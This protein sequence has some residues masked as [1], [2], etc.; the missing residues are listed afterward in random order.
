[1]GGDMAPPTTT[2]PLAIARPCTPQTFLR[3]QTCPS[4]LDPTN[5]RRGANVTDWNLASALLERF[6][7][8]EKM[9]PSD[10]EKLVSAVFHACGHPVVGS[11]FVESNNGIDL[12]IETQL[13][14]ILQ[15]ISVEVKYRRGAA[16]E[17]SIRQLISSRDIEQLHRTMIVSR[18]G[19]T[20]GALRM[21]A[22]NGVGNLDLL[23]PSDLHNWL[24][25]H[26]PQVKT[27]TSAEL[28]VRAAMRSLAKQ[29]AEAPEELAKLEWRDLERVLREV[30]EGIGFGTHLTRPGKDGGF[31]LELTTRSN[32]EATTYLVEVKHWIGQKLGSRHLNKFVQVTTSRRATG[33]LLL[34][35]SGFTTSFHEGFAEITAPVRLGDGAK[36]VSL[37][38]V[39]FR[40]Q[41]ALW[42]ED[43]SLEDTLFDGTL[44]PQRREPL[45]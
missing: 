7:R 27:D 10:A 25:K 13:D 19:F 22:E 43:R 21:A 30:F 5:F 3:T 34:S 36:V 2:A 40:L 1:M 38:K 17:D 12:F 32:G 23:S 31:D 26:V 9:L 20:P 16:D 33:A 37:C 18:G 28:I 11:G 44:Q 15:R 6:E 39:F 42:V 14:G 4:C 35:T 41:S 45:F 29:V 8:E 24:A